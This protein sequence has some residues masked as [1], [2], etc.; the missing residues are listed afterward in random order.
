VGRQ[1]RKLNFGS[2]A[3]NRASLDTNPGLTESPRA[4]GDLFIGAAVAPAF[5]VYRNQSLARVGG[6]GGV[7]GLRAADFSGPSD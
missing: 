5:C 2:A 1:V 4:P 6:R 7:H 3:T